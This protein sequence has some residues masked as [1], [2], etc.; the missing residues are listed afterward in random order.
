MP[1]NSKNKAAQAIIFFLLGWVFLS[2]MLLKQQGPIEAFFQ[3]IDTI[4]EDI[5][6]GG[7]AGIIA[8]T[9]F[10]SLLYLSR[11]FVSFF[12][13]RDF[14]YQL[15]KLLFFFD[16]GGSR[17]KRI[18][19]IDE[20]EIENAVVPTSSVGIMVSLMMTYVFGLFAVALLSQPLLLLNPLSS[21]EIEGVV[22]FSLIPILSFRGLA[23]LGYSSHVKMTETFVFLCIFLSLLCSLSMWG[24]DV[25]HVPIFPQDVGLQ[26]TFVYYS[27]LYSFIPT[28]MEGFA[29]LALLFS[30]GDKQQ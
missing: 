2:N 24:L 22:L 27:I 1:P 26:K 30:S 28:L 7:G 25:V 14:F 4:S 5:V 8:A 29:W 13:R 21:E 12:S 19:A 3:I 11:F 6:M 15:E 23:L 20:E 10:A 17:I 18:I 9:I 16:T